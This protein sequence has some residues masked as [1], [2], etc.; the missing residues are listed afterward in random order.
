MAEL[1]E[2]VVSALHELHTEASTLRSAVQQDAF[3]AQIESEQHTDKI[4]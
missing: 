4:R 2:E 3:D 1:R